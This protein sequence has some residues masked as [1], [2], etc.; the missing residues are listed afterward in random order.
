[1]AKTDNRVEVP[2]N[3]HRQRS[4]YTCLASSFKTINEHYGVDESFIYKRYVKKLRALDPRLTR[5]SYGE[6]A[7]K[8][9]RRGRDI[10]EYAITD[11]LGGMPT[12]DTIIVKAAVR[13]LELYDV[14]LMSTNP[15]FGKLTC[16]ILD[17]CAK[18]D[19]KRKWG[20]TQYEMLQL[21]DFLK[22]GGAVEKVE[23][24]AGW[25]EG[26]IREEK[27][28]V[29]A[30]SK[31]MDSFKLNG[32]AVDGLHA[33]VVRGFERDSGQPDEGENSNGETK[34][35]TGGKILIADPIGGEMEVDRELFELVWGG[36]AVHGAYTIVLRTK[37]QACSQE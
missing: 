2:V 1:M 7:G 33:Y 28:P 11:W 16:D 29:I 15:L 9:M 36:T 37:K 4:L 32:Q 13:A 5:A 10:Q 8:Y 17:E 34:R 30:V 20:Y 27:I 12:S 3:L 14:T 21:R 25:L 31:P 22:K 18:D 6:L 24:E 23:P 19:G 35:P 26:L